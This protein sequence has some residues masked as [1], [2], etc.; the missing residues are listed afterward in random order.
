LDRF[1]GFVHRTFNSL[2]CKFFIKSLQNIYLNEGGLESVFY[3]SSLHSTHLQEGIT[4]FREVFFSIPHEKRT[5][6]HVSN[7]MN[8]SSA[9]RLNMFLRWMVR[10]A[11]KGVDFGIWKK[12]K[13]NEL[14]IP[15]DVHTGNVSRQLG[16][17]KRKQNDAK[18]VLELDKFLRKLDP[19]DPVK[20]DFALFGLG[21]NGDI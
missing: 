5:M 6:K 9:K 10:D 1:N 12:I 8:G 11:S 17:L 19:V 15:L 4:R 18:A 2:D 16:M 3:N 7:P 13:P 21:V 20:Y 14:S